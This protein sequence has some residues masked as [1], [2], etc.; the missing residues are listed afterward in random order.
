MNIAHRKNPLCLLI[1]KFTFNDNQYTQFIDNRSVIKTKIINVNAT[2]YQVNDSQRCTVMMT[3]VKFNKMFV[4]NFIN[5]FSFRSQSAFSLHLYCDHYCVGEET[6]HIKQ[7][8]WAI[9]K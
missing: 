5:C 1:N 6:K 9:D 7:M 3:F 4:R 2:S 8:H